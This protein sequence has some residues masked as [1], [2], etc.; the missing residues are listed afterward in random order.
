MTF[1]VLDNLGISWRTRNSVVSSVTCAWDSASGIP[2][3]TFKKIQ[4]QQP[5]SLTP[6]YGP[7]HITDRHRR[8]IGIN[9][10]EN[11]R[12]VYFD[13]IRSKFGI[14]SNYLSIING[15]SLLQIAFG[16]E[17]LPPTDN[18]FITINPNGHYE[19]E[20]RFFGKDVTVWLRG[21]STVHII[22]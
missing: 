11:N 8:S 6:Q 15:D 12:G 3:Y 2:D 17:E 4:L 20:G 10:S 19:L 9:L 13:Y 5:V 22:L 1:I 18:D 21:T 14:D 7:A 16:P